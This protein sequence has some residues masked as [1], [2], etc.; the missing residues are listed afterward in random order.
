MISKTIENMTHRNVMLRLNSGNTLFI[1]P[2]KP[3]ESIPVEEVSDNPMVDKLI[4]RRIIAMH[5]VE[6][7]QSG[8]PA[9]S[10]TKTKSRSKG[11]K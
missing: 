4:E 6:T 8:A 2:G 11:G 5:T 1:E 7:K 9:K 10:K 3:S